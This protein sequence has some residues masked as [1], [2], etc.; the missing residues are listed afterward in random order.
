MSNPLR[1]KALHTLE[2][3]K[4]RLKLAN[5]TSFPVSREL[6]LA[7]TPSYEHGE[8][9]HRQKETA[10]AV[11]LL[12]SRPG[13]S[14]ASAKDI[15]D[16]VQRASRGGVLTPEEMLA[17]ASTVSAANSTKSAIG[18]ASHE[19]PILA[20]LA[21]EMAGCREVEDSIR[22]SVNPRGEVLDSASELLSRVRTEGRIAHDRLMARLNE[23]VAANI[24]KVL[25][26][27]FITSRGDRY[28]L[29]VKTEARGQFP[30]LIHDISSSGATVFMEPLATVEL[31]NAWRELKLMEER[32]TERVLRSL[33]A[34]IGDRADDILGDVDLLARIDLVLAKARLSEA[35]R[36][37]APVIVEGKKPYVS[38]VNARHPLLGMNVVP[39]SV[40]VG[41]EFTALVISGP[42]TGG[43]T[44]ALKT[45]GLLALMAQAGLQVPATEGS[46]A[47][48]FDG[49]YADIGDE[50][51]IE[52]SLS[53][54]SSHMVNISQILKAATGRSLVLLDELGAGT[55]P[56]EGT[57]L[58][59]AILSH[60][61]RQ[62]TATVV[63][64]HHSELKAF[65]HATP[66]M[67]NASVEFDPDTLA[68]TFKL[69]MGL[70]GRSNALAIAA[71]LGLSKELLDQARASMG[72]QHAEME[73]L[74]EDVRK[75]RELARQ[76]RFA[77]QEARAA[78]QRA[79]DEASK[80]LADLERQKRDALDQ[81][82][83]EVQVM[84]EDLKSRLRRAARNAEAASKR[85]EKTARHAKAEVEAVSKPAPA[86]EPKP[87]ETVAEA[88]AEVEAVEA[89]LER[90]RWTPGKVSKQPVKSGT[91]APGDWVEVR[92][93]SQ[94]AE[95]I[96]APDPDGQVEL[97]IGPMRVR[98]PQSDILQQHAP[99]EVQTAPVHVSRPPAPERELSLRAMR[100]EVAMDLLESYLDSAALAGL[101]SVRI[102]HG[103]GQGI[104]RNAVR[105][106]LT[107]HPLVKSF[108]LAD[109]KDGGEGVTVVELR[110]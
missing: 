66:G 29:A 103:K 60:L 20:G 85:I 78:A 105:E 67:E 61:V 37:H 17:I 40:E 89:E 102:V 75:E 4:V 50:Q 108:R 72:P 76:N 64:T 95:V 74:L 13:F 55:D 65:A 15:R 38:F 26:E 62:G 90:P 58:A 6:A 19:A 51:S 8:V 44:V 84:A 3:E 2:F 54:F 87:A 43:K 42:N 45:L 71:R 73:N 16:P 41:R 88:R 52:Q 33:S 49:I 25:Q 14:I 99:P 77:A 30:G 93:F 10:E 22:R 68:P 92:G 35:M 83:V 81:R 79:K 109:P 47:A 28:V 36:A 100:A 110:G 18:R 98:V 9:S 1:E 107:G 86:P 12:E 23:I 63:T 91:V 34:Q 57:A 104:L 97:Q 39:T 70:P 59:R 11:L 5:L 56:Q 96:S 21:E 53:T 46:E 7:L 101:E 106:R 27:P 94:P 48:V 31:C 69:S 24:G 80:E 82:R 32:E